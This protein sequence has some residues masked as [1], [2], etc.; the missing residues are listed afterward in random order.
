MQV[1]PGTVA[2]VIREYQT[3]MAPDW[4]QTEPAASIETGALYFNTCARKIIAARRTTSL[5][6][7][8]VAE[9]YNVGWAGFISGTRNQ[10]YGLKMLAAQA[11]W[12]FVDN[13]A[14]MTIS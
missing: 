7:A 13:P 14:S 4:P 3:V 2:E 8:E 11:Q 6:L 9:A 12:G 5:Y 10:R 1:I